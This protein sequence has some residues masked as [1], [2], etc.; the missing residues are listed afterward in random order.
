MES[1]Y[2]RS[3]LFDRGGCLWWSGLLF[4]LDGLHQR[5]DFCSEVDLLRRG[6][7]W[8]CLDFGRVENWSS[9][10]GRPH[11]LGL[12]RRALAVVFFNITCSRCSRVR[13]L[14][15]SIVVYL[16][17]AWK[18]SLL[19]EVA[20]RESWND[21]V[22]VWSRVTS[23]TKWIVLLMLLLLLMCCDHVVASCSAVCLC[24]TILRRHDCSSKCRR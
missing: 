11:G 8:S 1:T 2:H 4:C 12:D 10:W 18:W 17:Q 13:D 14:S 5:I 6:R 3:D 19:D 7:C 15:T 24:R 20:I 9:G 16:H 22:C 21:H 23:K